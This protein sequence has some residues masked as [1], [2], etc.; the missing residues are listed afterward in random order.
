MAGYSDGQEVGKQKRSECMHLRET[1]TCEDCAKSRRIARIKA[2]MWLA[3]ACAV[4][5]AALLIITW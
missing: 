2:S 5:F 4:V 1:A 3:A